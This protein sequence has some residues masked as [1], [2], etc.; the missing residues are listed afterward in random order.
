MYK[1]QP[2]CLWLPERYRKPGTS[3]YVQGVE[4]ASDFDK[5]VPDG[6]DVISLPAADYLMFQGE[7]FEEEDYCEA[8]EAVQESAGKYEP[9]V[10][11]YQWDAENPRIQ[12]EPVGVRGYI[13]LYA[14]KKIG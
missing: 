5:P 14:V 4:V 12:L 7:P 9:S 10:I 6:F 2:V 3:V 1:R 13:E 8:I 11:G